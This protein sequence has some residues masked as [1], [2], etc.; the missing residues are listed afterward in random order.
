MRD[1]DWFTL[2]APV[3]GPLFDEAAPLKVVEHVRSGPSKRLL[4]FVVA[5][6]GV[7][8]ASPAA[9]LAHSLSLDNDPNRPLWKYL[10]FGFLHMATGWD[11][12]L[13]ILG[14]V[15]IAGGVGTAAKLISLFVAAV[16][17]RAQHHAADRDPRPAGSST[18]RW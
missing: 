5:T 14:V 13:F 4:V 6:A 16:R 7:F 8:L 10:W 12:L 17:C 9:A 11:H 1:D 18:R 3:E 2:F 15:L